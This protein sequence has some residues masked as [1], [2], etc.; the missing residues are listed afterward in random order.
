MGNLPFSRT[1][2]L[3]PGD[4][5]PSALL[6]EIQDQIIGGKFTNTP[7][8]V[9]ASSFVVVSGSPTLLDGVWSLAAA[10]NTIWEFPI[11]LPPG[12]SIDSATAYYVRHVTVDISDSYA[13]RIKH[14]AGVVDGAAVPAAADVTSTV[15]LGNAT[16][17]YPNLDSIALTGL[18]SVVDVNDLLW[19]QFKM[20]LN[21]SG[22]PLGQFWG[23]RYSVSRG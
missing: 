16:S 2:N 21:G 6:N 9:P 10:G 11:R 22:A 1:A 4:A 14:S 20:F 12:T 5:I 17:N 8:F 15:K 13:L 18:P 7:V 3:V 19:W 23:L